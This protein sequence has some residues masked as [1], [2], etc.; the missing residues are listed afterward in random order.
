MDVQM[1]FL[2]DELNEADVYEWIIRDYKKEKIECPHWHETH[3]FSDWLLYQFS[4][5]CGGSICDSKLEKKGVRF[6]AFGGS[7]LRVEYKRFDSYFNLNI[8]KAKILKTFGIKDDHKDIL[9]DC[10]NG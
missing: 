4:H 7:Y 10:E 2:N 1:T 8:P 9:K 3:T 6:Y 5:Y